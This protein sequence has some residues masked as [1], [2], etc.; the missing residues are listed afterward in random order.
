MEKNIKELLEKVQ[1][2][3]A[4]AEETLTLLK[5]LNISLDVLRVV[6]EEIKAEQEKPGLAV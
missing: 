3:Q 6:L 2:G 1:S 4:T 5:T